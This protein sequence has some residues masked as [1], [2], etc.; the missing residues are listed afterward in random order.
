M[1]VTVVSPAKMAERIEMLFG[2]R[3][4]VGPR[5]HVL[6]G[7]EHRCHLAN[8]SELSMCGGNAACCQ[9]TLTTCL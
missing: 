9:N 5:K 4:Q 6:G 2:L 3:A 1:S 7:G 8:T